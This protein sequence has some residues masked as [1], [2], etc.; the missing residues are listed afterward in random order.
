MQPGQAGVAHRD[1][2]HRAATQ[3]VPAWEEVVDDAGVRTGGCVQA[4][5][6]GRRPTARV[7]TAP[8]GGCPDDE[9]GA[10]EQG[11]HA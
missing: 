3:G 11:W 7:G 9:L 8:R 2:G 10:V 6:A 5:Q 4:E 1:G